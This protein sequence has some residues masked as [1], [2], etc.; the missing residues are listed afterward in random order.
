MGGSLT[1][2]V[3]TNK[4]FSDLVTKVLYG[5]NCRFYVP[6]LLYNIYDD[7]RAF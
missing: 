7:I 6:N 5:E 1:G 4:N 2:N 3:D